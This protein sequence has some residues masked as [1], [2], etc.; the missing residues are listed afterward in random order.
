MPKT[1]LTCADPHELWTLSDCLEPNGY[2]DLM[3]ERTAR[4]GRTGRRVVRRRAR[5]ATDKAMAVAFEGLPPDIWPELLAYVD[6]KRAEYESRQALSTAK[7]R[8]QVSWHQI[9][10]AVRDLVMAKT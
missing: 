5:P 7:S 3:V 1:L 10:A 2:P 6:A 4:A 9:D 8:H